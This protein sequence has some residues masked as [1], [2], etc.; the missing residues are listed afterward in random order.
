EFQAKL[1]LLGKDIFFEEIQS[2]I[3]GQVFDFFDKFSEYTYLRIGLLG[4][5]QLINAATALGVIEALRLLNIF[6][7]ADAIKKGLAQTVWPGRFEI[8]KT[9]PFII[10]DGA[11]NIAS[12]KELK[13]TVKKIFGSQ[14]VIVVLGI[15]QDKDIKGICKELEPIS[16]TIILTKA[17]N[18]RAT[19][20]KN[21]AEFFKQSKET[22]ITSSVKEALE[23]AKSI[24]QKTDIILVS[25]SLFVVGEARGLC[26]KA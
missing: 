14:E 12:A 6:V 15:S 9:N 23:L 26:I 17:D 2:D 4:R 13:E 20:P 18:P 1:Y 24:A 22:K 11:Q 16:K 3:G 10:L 8:T 21:I 5:H 25:G 7:P 19:E